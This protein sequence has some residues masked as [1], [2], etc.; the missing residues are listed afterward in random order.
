MNCLSDWISPR[1][2]QAAQ[3]GRG[4]PT[5]LIGIIAAI[6]ATS[7]VFA[8]PL[9][10]AESE[11]ITPDFSGYWERPEP[12]G[13][14]ARFY[15][16]GDGPEPVDFA[17]D[18]GEPRQG[19]MY[20]GEDSNPILQPHAAAALRAQR[21]T[22]NRGQA[23]LSAWALCWPVGV[24]LSFSMVNAV[25]FLQ[26]ENEVTITYQ[27]G[28][29]V[30]RIYLNDAHPE[31]PDPSWFGHSV[32]HYEGDNTLVVDT[33]AQDPRAVI[34]RFGTPK[35]EA[36]RITEKY[37]LSADGKRIDV[38]FNVE[39]PETFTTAW[40]ATVGYEKHPPRTGEGPQ[41][42]IFAE[43]ICPENNRGTE[44]EDLAVPISAS[45]EF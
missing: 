32:G 25:Q 39:D 38:V 19:V 28:Q 41:E 22:Y 45:P 21:E 1:R 6:I 26:T 13:E 40:S 27:R 42:A 31:N 23:V 29:T 14:V 30:R 36:M 43:I 5:A 8:P 24:P 9:N 7:T 12:T 18:V 17:S 20:I 3:C 11:R 4:V 15:P 44:G 16:I 37:T 33:I 10:A 34:D 35:S 2:S